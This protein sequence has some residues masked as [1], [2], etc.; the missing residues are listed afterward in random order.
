MPAHRRIPPSAAEV[1]ERPAGRLIPLVLAVALLL[2]AASAAAAQEVPPAPPDDDV[3]VTLEQ[4]CHETGDRRPV[5][6]A[7]ARSYLPEGYDLSLIGGMANVGFVDYVCGALSI[8]GHRAR[9]TIVSMGTVSVTR[10][11]DYLLWIGTDNPLQFARLRQLGVNVFF[12]PRSTVEVSTTSEGFLQLRVE[13][14]GNGPG[15]LDYTRTITTR[16][17]TPPTGTTAESAG[18]F[19][20]EGSKGEVRVDFA[21]HTEPGWPSTVCFELADGSL[22]LEYGIT[23]FPTEPSC[24]PNARTLIR[25]SWEGTWALVGA[26]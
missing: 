7:L 3:A 18:L 23:E 12:I 8:D 19:W 15:G 21:N 24:F 10:E 22:P 13:Y 1:T 5:A 14:V 4:D 6:P 26:G 16:T 9:P 17:A 25:G 2:V 11:G 20:H